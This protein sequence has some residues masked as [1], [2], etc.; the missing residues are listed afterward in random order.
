MA[1]SVVH[2]SIGCRDAHGLSRHALLLLQVPDPAP[3]RSRLH[4]DLRPREGGRDAEVDRLLGIGA[5][6]HADHRGS[7]G[8]GTG[9]VTLADP[10]GNLCCVLPSEAELEAAPPQV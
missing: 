1:S 2:T 4:L 8:P 5:V 7:Y 9:W 3:G 6:Q 10:E